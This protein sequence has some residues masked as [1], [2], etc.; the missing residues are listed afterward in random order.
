[1][2]LLDDS[3]TKEFAE[4]SLKEVSN[5]HDRLVDFEFEGVLFENCQFESTDFVQCSFIN[6]KFSNCDF[7]NATLNAC[8][9][10]ECEFSN[11]KLLGIDWSN[12]GDLFFLKF[13]S[14]VLNYGN[15][16]NLNLTKTNFDG[17]RLIDT[18]FSKSKL[19]E[20]S[21]RDCDL[22]GT[23]FTMADLQKADFRDARN[24]AID[25]KVAKI[26]NAKFSMPEAATLLTSLGL[27]IDF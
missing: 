23:I 22:G 19:V 27:K 15:L 8:A 3:E 14:C 20:A 7:S 16:S 6:C 18:D 5:S 26:K 4:L 10:N 9:L 11:C 2:N 1:M 21:F 24:Y 25:I 12:A 17:S 13:E